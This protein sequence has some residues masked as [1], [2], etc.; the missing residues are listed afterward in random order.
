MLRKV[1]NE[2]KRNQA[3]KA[4][5]AALP[6]SPAAALQGLVRLSQSL[7]TI[8]EKE[9]QALLLNDMLAFSILQYEKEKLAGEYAKASAEFRNRLEEFRNAD[10]ALLDRLE[11]LQKQLAEKASGNNMLVEQ[12]HQRAQLN[13]RN[14]IK[15]INELSREKRIRFEE[16]ETANEG[17]QT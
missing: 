9:T 13:A 4:R 12:A 1:N 15:T 16:T 5:A 14:G 6:L 10:R 3:A 11:R 7:L 8:A 17:V 2:N